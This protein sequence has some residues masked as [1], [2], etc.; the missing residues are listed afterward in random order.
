MKKELNIFL[1]AVMFFMRIPVKVNIGYSAEEANR[2]IRY[3]PL[4]GCI[5]GGISA[6]VLWL[7]LFVFPV[8]VSIVLSMATGIVI[9]G[10]FH[11]DGFADV[12]DGFGGGWD[13]EKILGIMKDSRVGAFGVI[14]IVVVLLL[15]YSS[16]L[17]VKNE[18]MIFA[19]IAGHSISRFAAVS[20]MLS[21]AYVRGNED[22]KAKPMAKTITVYELLIAFVIGILP[23]ALF[24]NYMFFLLII[25]VFLAKFL[26]MRFF[27]RW[28]GGYTGDCLGAIQQVCEIVFYLSLIV[29]CRYIS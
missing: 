11:E 24:N 27:N 28:I 8:S 7:S 12:C 6:F 19:I 23:L 16:L 5:V 20:V 26:M 10:A 2:A 3:L 9:T 1:A 25:P 13:K 29:L 4:I 17:S 22:S 15:K 14:G 21:N 18:L